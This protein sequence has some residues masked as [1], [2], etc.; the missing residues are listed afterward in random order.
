M[1]LDDVSVVSSS[2]LRKLPNNEDRLLLQK[3]GPVCLGVS[4]RGQWSPRKQMLHINCL[5]LLAIAS[6]VHIFER[7][8]A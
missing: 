5:E 3:V 7:D 2:S 1:F 8:K 6:E 4:A